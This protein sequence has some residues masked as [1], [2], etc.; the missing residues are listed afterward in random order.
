M[1]R[2]K[3]RKLNEKWA[4]H[5]V[6]CGEEFFC[7]NLPGEYFP[8]LI[9]DFTNLISNSNSLSYS[10]NTKPWH[11]F[12]QSWLRG[13]GTFPTF[14]WHFLTFLRTSYARQFYR[15]LLLFIWKQT[16]I[17][18][19]WKVQDRVALVHGKLETRIE[20]EMSHKTFRIPVGN[21][22]PNFCI[23]LQNLFWKCFMSCWVCL[24][25]TFSKSSKTSN[26]SWAM[27][28]PRKSEKCS[29]IGKFVVIHFMGIIL[30]SL[31]ATNL[32]WCCGNGRLF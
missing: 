26:F 29:L 15:F 27:K 5:A 12:T 21:L 24:V 8:H 17:Y 31:L 9:S 23:N 6:I 18:C 7:I 10:L 13:E 32:T 16:K 4:E 2:R 19:K 30:D 14:T 3:P 20:W 11:I 1:K 22:W 25:L 28:I